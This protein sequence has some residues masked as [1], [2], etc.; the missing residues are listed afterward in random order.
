MFRVGPRYAELAQALEQYLRVG[1][2]ILASIASPTE[3]LA[4]IHEMQ[5]LLGCADAEL[6]DRKRLLKGNEH[7]DLLQ[8]AYGGCDVADGPDDRGSCDHRGPESAPSGPAQQRLLRAS[9]RR[10]QKP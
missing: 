2:E 5:R 1:D 3:K 4:A 7:L 8:S 9:S 6:G 10:R